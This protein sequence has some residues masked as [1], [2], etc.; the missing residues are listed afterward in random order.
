M[1]TTVSSHFTITFYTKERTEEK[2]LAWFDPLY[3]ISIHNTKRRLK[4]R[5]VDISKVGAII[6]STY[7][8]TIEP[9]LLG[10]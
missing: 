6:R 10:E 3:T 1:V 8:E 7:V 4:E 2:L 9:N 5:Y